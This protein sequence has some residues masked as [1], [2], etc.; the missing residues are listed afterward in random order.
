MNKHSRSIAQFFVAGGAVGLLTLFGFASL[1]KI[2]DA[3]DRMK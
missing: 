1:E 2:Q 3:R